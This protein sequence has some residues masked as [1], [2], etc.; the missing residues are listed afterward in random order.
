MQKSG[1]FDPLQTKNFLAAVE[2]LVL[3]FGHLWKKTQKILK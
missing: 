2:H 3:Y 1:A